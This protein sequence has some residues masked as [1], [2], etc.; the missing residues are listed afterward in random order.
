M[1]RIPVRFG[2]LALLLTVITICVAVFCILEV[3]TAGADK[4]LAERYAENASAEYELEAEGQKWLA[5]TDEKIASGEIGSGKFSE[6]L[7]AGN[8]QL[9]ITIQVNGGTYQILSWEVGP[10]GWQPDTQENLWGN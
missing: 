10:Y 9:A 1:R 6:T 2:P 8:K 5:E 7:K 3:S 4:R